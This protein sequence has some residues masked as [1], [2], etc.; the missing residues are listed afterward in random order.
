MSFDP[1]E[2]ICAAVRKH[3]GGT[4]LPQTEI[5]IADRVMQEL[6]T[7]GFVIVK[8][9]PT[10]EAL[11]DGLS[12]IATIGSVNQRMRAIAWLPEGQSMTV[13]EA[14]VT[15]AMSAFYGERY[16]RDYEYLDAQ[17]RKDMRLALVRALE[18]VPQSSGT[19][20]EQAKRDNA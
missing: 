1:R 2:A 4:S 6:E 17:Y 9:Q 14:M 10:K 20:Q 11:H 19:S 13:T 3:H 5:E 16:A 8:V 18:L 12:Q 7:R 15:A